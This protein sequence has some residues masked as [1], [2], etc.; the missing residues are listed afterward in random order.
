MTTWAEMAGQVGGDGPH[1]QVVDVSDVG[2]FQQVGA[3]GVEVDR[4]GGGLQQ[5]PHGRLEQTP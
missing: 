1:V 5:D 4:L 3:H 2:R